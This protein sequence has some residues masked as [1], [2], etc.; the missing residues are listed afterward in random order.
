[1]GNRNVSDSEGGLIGMK[2]PID[3]AF[4]FHTDAG[5][6]PNDSI[7]GTLGIYSTTANQ[8]LFPNGKSRMASRVDHFSITQLGDNTITT[9]WRDLNAP[10]E[11]S[12]KPG[13][14]RG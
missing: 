7:I 1:M 3:L 9:R 10:V 4:A 11:P 13:K 2:I 6:T 5:V 14:F 12:A 8:G